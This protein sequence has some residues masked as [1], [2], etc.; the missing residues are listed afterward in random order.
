M[1]GARVSMLVGDQLFSFDE[2]DVMVLYEFLQNPKDETLQ[3]LKICFWEGFNIEGGT[4]W[5]SVCSVTSEGKFSD[6][7]FCSLSVQFEKLTVGWTVC[8][9]LGDGDIIVFESDV[10]QLCNRWFTQHAKI[11]RIDR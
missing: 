2:R 1:L 6:A 9:S 7:L 11:Q 8:A 3:N 10:N 5:E 4:L